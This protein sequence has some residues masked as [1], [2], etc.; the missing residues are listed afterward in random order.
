M[1]ENILHHAAHDESRAM[2]TTAAQNP[3]F[4]APSMARK[5]HAPLCP[6]D[7]AALVP[8]KSDSPAQKPAK[9]D[10]RSAEYLLKSGLAGGLAGCAVWSLF[11][12]IF[13]S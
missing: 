11:P 10:K 4:K 1:S 3:L 7:E 13:F 8:E 5:Q 12:A 2:A 6:T 9:V